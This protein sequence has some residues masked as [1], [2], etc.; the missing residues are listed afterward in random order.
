MYRQKNSYV[1]DLIFPKFIYKGNVIP[2]K[3][4]ETIFVEPDKLIL[5]SMDKRKEP[6]TTK[7]IPE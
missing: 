5:K 7:K 1:K 6:R 3:I 2:N 4:P